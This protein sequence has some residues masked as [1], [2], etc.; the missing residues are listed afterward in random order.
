M[1][2]N[3]SPQLPTDSALSS[4]DDKAEGFEELRQRFDARLTLLK[5]PGANEKLRTLMNQ[6]IDLSGVI[7][8]RLPPT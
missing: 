4:N 5:A 1:S 2:E 7:I 6:P 3:A 8:R